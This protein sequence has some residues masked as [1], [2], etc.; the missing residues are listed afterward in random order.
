VDARGDVD[1]D[2]DVDVLELRINER[3]DTDAANAGL[4]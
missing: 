4:E 3:V 2:A 1:V